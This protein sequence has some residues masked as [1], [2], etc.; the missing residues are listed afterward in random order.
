MD[1]R[2]FHALKHMLQH[3]PGCMSTANRNP[4]LELTNNL[5]FQAFCSNRSSQGL[6]IP[7]SALG[8]GLPLPPHLDPSSTSR[9]FAFQP[10]FYMFC[11]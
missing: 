3:L 11:S 1:Q 7:N 8:L 4:H 10:G 2:D 6:T 5:A 9:F